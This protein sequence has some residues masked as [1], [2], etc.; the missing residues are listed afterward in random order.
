MSL[1][2]HPSAFAIR[3]ISSALIC[4]RPESMSLKACFEKPARFATAFC[5]KPLSLMIV[6]MFIRIIASHSTVYHLVV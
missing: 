1:L 3:G 5:M 6:L 4:R 2:S